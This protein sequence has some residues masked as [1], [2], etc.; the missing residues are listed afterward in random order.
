MTSSRDHEHNNDDD[1]DGGD[2]FD[3]VG[4]TANSNNTTK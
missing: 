3:T 2:V 4:S 1:Q